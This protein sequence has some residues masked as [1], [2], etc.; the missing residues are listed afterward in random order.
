MP[1]GE[2]RLIEKMSDGR[3]GVRYKGSERSS[4]IFETGDTLA[5]VRMVNPD[6]Y[7]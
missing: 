4:D 1:T 2:H 6:D 5:H 3:F 7:Y